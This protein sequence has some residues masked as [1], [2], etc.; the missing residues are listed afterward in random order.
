MTAGRWDSP[1]MPARYTKAQAGVRKI[2][3]HSRQARR[4]QAGERRTL[5]PGSGYVR[6]PE[7]DPGERVRRDR[8]GH[9]RR[10]RRR[11]GVPAGRGDAPE[12]NRGTGPR[13]G[14]SQQDE[15]LNQETQSHRQ[16]FRNI[17][18]LRAGE[19]GGGIRGTVPTRVRAASRRNYQAPTG[20]RSRGSPCRA[21]TSPTPR[22]AVTGSHPK[23]RTP[24]GPAC[25]SS[26]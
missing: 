19:P 21:E 13:N 2:H 1:T 20:P 6:D 12:G 11:P 9:R 8:S 22:G 15:Q 24:R 5:A 23:S 25:G 17:A 3:E 18:E 16:I 26:R 7:G 4:H 14:H 10:Q